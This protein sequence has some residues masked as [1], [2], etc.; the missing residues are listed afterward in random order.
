MNTMS[1]YSDEQQYIDNAAS[2]RV[3]TSEKKQRFSNNS[4]RFFG[5]FDNFAVIFEDFVMIL[6]I[7]RWLY[8]DFVAIFYDFYRDFDDSAYTTISQRLYN[9]F[10]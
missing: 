8:N 1:H 3:V 7:Q 2:S 6:D 10:A 4:W 9:D 5:D